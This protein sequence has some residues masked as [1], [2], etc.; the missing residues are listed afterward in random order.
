MAGTTAEQLSAGKRYEL[1]LEKVAAMSSRVTLAPET[2]MTVLSMPLMLL[3]LTLL[4]SP[5]CP[6]G[7]AMI[8]TRLSIPLMLLMF[9]LLHS[10]PGAMVALS[11]TV[12]VTLLSMPLTLL[13]T[14][15]LGTV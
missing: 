14:K 1:Y 7:D 3:M 9:T 10:T 11:A 2:M 13:M 8:L 15:L 12:M 4:H 5:G 6:S